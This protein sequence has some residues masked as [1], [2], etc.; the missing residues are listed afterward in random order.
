VKV[1]EEDLTARMTKC[2]K[3]AADIVKD[4]EKEING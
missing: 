1:L 4:K 2:E 3:R